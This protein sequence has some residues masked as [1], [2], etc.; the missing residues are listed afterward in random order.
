MI[1]ASPSPCLWC[2]A[3]FVTRVARWT[4]SEDSAALDAM[5]NLLD[6]AALDFNPEKPVPF[7]FS[8]N[9]IFS[10]IDFKKRAYCTGK[11]NRGEARQPPDLLGRSAIQ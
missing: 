11:G 8:D 2:A 9:V 6:T 10:C 7:E 1:R 5:E 3:N 4:E